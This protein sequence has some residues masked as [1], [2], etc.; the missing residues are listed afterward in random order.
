ML[1][2]Q[3]IELIERDIEVVN[4]DGKERLK[5]ALNVA[6]LWLKS[7]SQITNSSFANIGKSLS[8]YE[9]WNNSAILKKVDLQKFAA[10]I[11]YSLCC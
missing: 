1:K 10:S 2:N 8:A 6:R 9:E 7:S 5:F 4:P 3:D 11:H